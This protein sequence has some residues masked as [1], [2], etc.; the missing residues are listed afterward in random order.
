[1]DHKCVGKA[2]TL[3]QVICSGNERINL[4]SCSSPKFICFIDRVDYDKQV[5]FPLGT[6]AL[7][8]AVVVAQGVER[9][10]SVRVGQVQIPVAPR[11]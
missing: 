11:V 6:F 2:G 9:W 7:V 3:N 5:T 1:M 4:L 10:P 8:G